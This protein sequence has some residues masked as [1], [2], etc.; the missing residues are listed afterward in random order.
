VMDRALMD[1]FTTVEMEA[2]TDIQELDLLTM[3]YPTVEKKKLKAIA[4]I[5]SQTRSESRSENSKLTNCLST[6]TSVE[7]ASLIYDG[8]TLQEAAEVAIYPF[9]SQD[10]GLDSERTF[11]KQMVQKYC[12]DDK[13]SQLFTAGNTT[14]AK[15]D[16]LPF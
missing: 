3:M 1:R 15:S 16:P 9:F 4:E 11:V 6:R 14:T 2:L 5:S 8:F 7:L 13:D 12:G 10:G